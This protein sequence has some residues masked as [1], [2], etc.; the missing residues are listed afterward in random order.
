[1]V[2]PV[3][4]SQWKERWAARMLPPETDV[5]CAI[6]LRTPASRKKRTSSRLW[7]VARKQP[8]GRAN[9]IHLM[10]TPTLDEGIAA[11]GGRGDDH[12]RG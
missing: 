11:V 9:P 10:V 7:S 12:Y 2:D 4:R 8:L 1:M 6:R 3:Y 5:M